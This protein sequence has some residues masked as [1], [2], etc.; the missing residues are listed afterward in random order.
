MTTPWNHRYAQRMQKM[1]GSAIRELLKLTQNPDIISFAGGLP[2]PDVFPVE[3]FEIATDHV[4][5]RHGTQALQYS[6]T[7][8]YAPLREWIVRRMARYGIHATP[9]NVMIT[10]GS[11][12]A[13]DLIGKLLINPGDMILTEKPTYLG[14]LQAWRAYQAEFTAVPVDDEGLRVD[15][16]EEA[17]CAGPKFMYILPNFQNPA[18]VT[19]SAERRRELIA[20]ADRY[21]VP[22]I[23]DDPYGDLRYEGEH[24]P[25][26]V[27]LDCNQLNGRSDCFDRGNVI[28]LSTFSKTL[29]PGLRL[30]WVVA[31]VE[32]IQRCAV[33]K[34]GMDLHT[35]TFTQMIT[36]EV[37]TGLDTGEDFLPNHVRLIR[38]V[39]SERR[40][41][42][43]TAM[44]RYFPAG[45][46]WTRPQG[47]LF[48]WVTLPANLDSTALLP[49]A[50]ANNV[51]FVPGNSFYPDGSG[52]NTFRLN[53][54]YCNP[55][56][57]ETGI[58]RLGAVL[59]TAMESPAEE[60]L[61]LAPELELAL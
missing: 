49:A 7:E 53:F 33:A 2:A 45:V 34:Q 17:L 26:L 30:A 52:H 24:L 31:P 5:S 4:L 51:A 55:E 16:L 41:A 12:Q 50:L 14:A 56:L 32:V 15:L 60:S 54:S 22:I 21:G 9:E 28:Y 6:T 37:L 57:I 61:Q 1:G 42:M 43:L 36:H 18:G 58:Q 11:Q 10:S 13:L 38:E 19:L 44:T 47:G 39:Y 29:A 59:A 3:A 35:S 48:L 46:E 20:I 40:D 8:G 25:P 23:E 27:V